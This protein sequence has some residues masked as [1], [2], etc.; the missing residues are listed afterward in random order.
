MDANLIEAMAEM[1]VALDARMRDVLLASR[2]EGGNF[3]VANAYLQVH[4]VKLQVIAAQATASAQQRQARALNVATWCLA[5]CTAVLAAT[6]IIL[7]VVT[8]I[9]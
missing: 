2:G 7:V 9:K 3:P 1:D 5:I 6:T 8:A 4:L